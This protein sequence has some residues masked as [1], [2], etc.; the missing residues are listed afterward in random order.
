MNAS[1]REG[2]REKEG[3]RRKGKGSGGGSKE[4]GGGMRKG[5]EVLAL[6][7]ALCTSRALRRVCAD[8]PAM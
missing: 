2:R 4:G 7:R 8:G 3:R 5:A 6:V 1:R